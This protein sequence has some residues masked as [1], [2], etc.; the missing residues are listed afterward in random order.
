M[1]FIQNTVFSNFSLWLICLFI[2]VL[3]VIFYLNNNPKIFRR[4]LFALFTFF[5]LA[6]S[7]SFVSTSKAIENNEFSKNNII[8]I[9]QKEATT[10]ASFGFIFEFLKTILSSKISN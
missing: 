6:V 8:N 4:T 10:V 5:I 9:D 7:T 3:C 1:H 2:L